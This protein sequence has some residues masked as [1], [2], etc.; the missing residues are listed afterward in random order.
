MKKWN[1]WLG[2]LKQFGTTCPVY[3]FS[4]IAPPYWPWWQRYRVRSRHLPYWPRWVPRNNMISCSPKTALVTGVRLLLIVNSP[5]VSTW[6]KTTDFLCVNHADP[7]HSVADLV[8]SDADPDPQFHDS[9]PVV[10]NL[11]WLISIGTIGNPLWW[12]TGDNMALNKT[13]F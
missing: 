2:V 11:K 10:F 4:K 6:D 12:P 9:D 3:F 7:N 5:D 13:L 8:Q 1:C